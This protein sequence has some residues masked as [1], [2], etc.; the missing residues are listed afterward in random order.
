MIVMLRQTASIIRGLDVQLFAT[1]NRVLRDT[2]AGIA[3]V[4]DVDERVL[5]WH[6]GLQKQGLGKD[7]VPDVGM[8]APGLDQVH[9]NAK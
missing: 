3:D 1:G 5:G 6:S 4:H 9:L 8:D 2:A 7:T